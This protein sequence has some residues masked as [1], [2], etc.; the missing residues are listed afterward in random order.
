MKALILAIALAVGIAAPAAAAAWRYPALQFDV[1]AQKGGRGGSQER[2][3]DRESRPNRREER[4]ERQERRERLSEDERRSLH[5]DLDKA[6]REL[7]KP[8]SQ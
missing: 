7:Y 8:R 2:A 4:E 3:Q 6:N 1:Q 5:K